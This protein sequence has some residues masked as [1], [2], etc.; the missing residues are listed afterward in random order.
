VAYD[1]RVLQSIT[2]ELDIVEL[3]GL[4]REETRGLMEYYAASGMLRH[5]IDEQFVTEKWT[6]AGGGVVGEL[7]KAAVMSVR[8]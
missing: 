1:E 8:I 6:I 2:P 5:K 7:E 4:S 3:K